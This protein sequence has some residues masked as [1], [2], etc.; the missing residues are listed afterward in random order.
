M[1]P[2][3]NVLDVHFPIELMRKPYEVRAA[4]PSTSRTVSC[5]TH[6][7]K[8]AKKEALFNGDGITIIEKYC[9][10]CLKTETFS[11]IMTFY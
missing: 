2:S 11:A 10:D 3:D 8:V 6:C 7:G 1:E 5:C 9:E 4:S